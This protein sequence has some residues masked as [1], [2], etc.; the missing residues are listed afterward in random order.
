GRP[1]NLT[2]SH[3]KAGPRMWQ[4]LLKGWSVEVRG[5]HT[6]VPRSPAGWGGGGPAAVLEEIPP[7]SLLEEEKDRVRT[8]GGGS[9]AGTAG[10]RPHGDS[11]DTRDE[12]LIDRHRPWDEA[13][14]E[15][16]RRGYGFRLIRYPRRFR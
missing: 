10:A 16:P 11:E 4:D 9:L 7:Q 2:L 1:V 14:N 5:R 13:L 6:E 15:S 12:V 8:G 3:V